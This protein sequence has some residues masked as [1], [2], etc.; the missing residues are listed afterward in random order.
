MVPSDN[1]MKARDA[2]MAGNHGNAEVSVA[3]GLLL[4]LPSIV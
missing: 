1:L 2:E 3:V 4:E